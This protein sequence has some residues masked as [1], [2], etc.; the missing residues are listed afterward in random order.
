MFTV[1]PIPIPEDP[2]IRRPTHVQAP[3]A[4]TPSFVLTAGNKSYRHQYSNIYFLRLRL[5]QGYVEEQAR[6]RWGSIA[7]NPTYVPRVL[8]VVK[9]QLC[10]IIGTV[11]MHMPLKPNVIEDLGRDHSLPAPAPREKY[12]SEEDKVM[13]EDESG[14]LCLVGRRVQDTPLV[15]GIILGALGM[16][17]TSGDF[18]VVDLCVAGM[19]P[20]P[21]VGLPQWDGDADDM[22]V[23]D[24]EPS[25]EWVAIVSGLEVG[26]TS[27]A[28]A[29]ME[30]LVE[31]LTGEVGGVHD[32]AEASRIS[33][34][35]V[36]G[37]SL[38]PMASLDNA[39]PEETERK[40]KRYGNDNA[41]FSSHP[42]QNLSAHLVDIARSMPIH[43]LPGASDPSGTILPQ[44][45]LPRAM[46][47]HAAAFSSFSCE[48][49]P[50]YIRI[51]TGLASDSAAT[52]SVAHGKGKQAATSTA[53]SAS[54]SSA[55]ARTF[56]VH[57]GQPL[58]DL[59]KYMP[60][61]P[62]TRLTLAERT[63]HWRH[64][65]PT[66]P[67][68]LWCHPYFTADPFVI[69]Q[70]PDVYVIGNQPAFATQLVRERAEESAE[71]KRC[72]IVLV[73]G[74]RK[75]G[76]IVLVN[77]RTLAVRTVQFAVEGMSAGGGET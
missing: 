31:Y 1:D 28:D 70:T 9:G 77:L 40:P 62:I 57:S 37:N 54:T 35:I 64:L 55:P 76:T 43:L 49:N 44:Q 42:T 65:A 18:E 71:E 25:D 56:L 12:Y 68:T 41:S 52:A 29:Q 4:Q 50:T 15:T 34:L 63:L 45:S 66:A 21:R 5:L 48:T 36:A 23:D 24:E 47:G 7:G 30:M 69:T 67:D 14:R 61:P 60:T 10:F 22:D 13:L 51:G 74:F 2:L 72:R 32:Q 20:Q 16:E 58:D 33:R 3:P 26:A 38:A 73:P 8:D 46:F 59:F 75:T 11:Y 53:D 6:R 27:P 19:A 39:V 17:T